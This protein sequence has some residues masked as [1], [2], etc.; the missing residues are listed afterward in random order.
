MRINQ[1]QVDKILMEIFERERT[2]LLG[3]LSDGEKEMMAV[4]L[5]DL[6]IELRKMGYE[7]QKH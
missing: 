1:M 6:N 2:L 5:Y 3:N 4:I 7:V